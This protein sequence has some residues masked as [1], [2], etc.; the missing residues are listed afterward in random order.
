MTAAGRSQ[1]VVLPDLETLSRA[2]ADY[3][4]TAAR[5]AVRSRGGFAVALSG[6]STPHRLYS[7]LASPPWRD[8]VDWSRT[9][10]FWGDERCVPPDHP[11]S[12]YRLARDLLLDHVALPDENVH[13]PRAELDDRESAAAEYAVE[14][15]RQVPPDM[16]GKPRFGLMLLGMGAD[17]HTA[18][19][20]PGSALLRECSRLVAVSDRER[21]GTIRLTMTPIILQRAEKLLLLVAGED[22]APALR[23]VLEGEEDLDR[24]PAQLVRQARGKVRWLVDRAAASRLSTKVPASSLPT[25][26]PA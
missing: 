26:A 18:S 6:G 4:V 22:K 25:K 1:V 3:F 20:L 15:G 8:D 10:V 13:R 11:E 16:D 24:Y 2:A 14:I 5:A 12:N 7:L 17:G 23:E 21:D 9:H 19:L